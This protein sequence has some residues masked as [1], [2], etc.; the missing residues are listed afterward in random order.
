M[1]LSFDFQM[2][3]KR[4]TEKSNIDIKPR[5]PII[6]NRVLGEFWDNK[7]SEISIGNGY[8]IEL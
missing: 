6:E 8:W 2:I 3:N 4:I 7:F 5:K 1:A